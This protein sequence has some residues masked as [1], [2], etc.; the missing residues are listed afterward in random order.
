MEMTEQEIN[1]EIK[2]ANLNYLMLAQQMIRCDMAIAMY[3]LGITKEIAELI[4]GLSNLQIL[5]LSSSPSML[6]RFRFDDS[7]ILD[8][9]TNYT[10]DYSQ[11]QMHTSIIMASQ[12]A[13]TLA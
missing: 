3:R 5:K 12:T 10:K 7:V 1:A 6:A 13:E 11:A 4:V 9:L 2:D 8:M